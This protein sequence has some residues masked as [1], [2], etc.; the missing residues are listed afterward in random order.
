MKALSER[1][2][3]I[4]AKVIPVVETDSVEQKAELDLLWTGLCTL[5]ADGGAFSWRQ[6][7]SHV[8][9]MASSSGVFTG[10]AM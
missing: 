9:S 1:S 7:V 8:R 5:E 10:L 6:G 3:C 2:A 4:L